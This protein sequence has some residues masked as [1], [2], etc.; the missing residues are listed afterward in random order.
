[1]ARSLPVVVPSSMRMYTPLVPN[2]IEKNPCLAADVLRVLNM[3]D[4]SRN[5]HYRRVLGDKINVR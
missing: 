2:L 4:R 5:L 3:V 1:M